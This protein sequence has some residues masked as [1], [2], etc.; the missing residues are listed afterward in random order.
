MKK[1]V[2]ALVL[3]FLLS[4]C[5]E[6]EKPKKIKIPK[7]DKYSLQIN[8]AEF[9]WVIKSSQPVPDVVAATKYT[10]E[11]KGWKLTCIVSDLF[12]STDCRLP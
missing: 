10:L 11:K 8:T 1:I 5:T 2:L 4:G 9:G 12:K 3:G 7:F 6:I